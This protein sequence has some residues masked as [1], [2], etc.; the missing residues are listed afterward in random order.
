MLAEED[1]QNNKGKPDYKFDLYT[2]VK[3]SWIKK[4]KKTPR[5]IQTW[6]KPAASEV[7]RENLLIL[8]GWGPWP[9]VPNVTYVDFKKWQCPL[10]LF[11][12]FPHRF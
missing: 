7:L 10:S 12:Q 6:Y 8:V 2:C 11:L 4:K 3:K 1:S 5:M 9:G